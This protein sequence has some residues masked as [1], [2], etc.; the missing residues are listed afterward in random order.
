MSEVVGRCIGALFSLYGSRSSSKSHNSVRL[1]CRCNSLIPPVE[2]KGV[3]LPQ[4][5]TFLSLSLTPGEARSRFVT[6][7]SSSGAN[8]SRME[9]SNS[10]NGHRSNASLTHVQQRESSSLF[11]SQVL[12]LCRERL[13]R[14]YRQASLLR[15]VKRPTLRCNLG[16]RDRWSASVLTP[17]NGSIPPT[18]LRKGAHMSRFY[19]PM[20]GSIP[21]LRVYSIH[22]PISLNE[23]LSLI[24][25]GFLIPLFRFNLQREGFFFISGKKVPELGSSLSFEWEVLFWND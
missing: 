7:S 12:I 3:G 18:D 23:T 1:R 6:F 2:S 24:T 17:F 25:Y 21:S 20:D 16:N 10:S 4:V 9:H 5:K 8:Q 15:Q 14:L 19:T 11:W 22:M 13:F